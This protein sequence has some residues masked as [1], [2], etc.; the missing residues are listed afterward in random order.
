[1]GLADW[2]A[3]LLMVTGVVGWILYELYGRHLLDI[4]V[5][6]STYLRMA[7]GAVVILYLYL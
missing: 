5:S 3:E 4:V 2:T 6:W 1:M 7:G